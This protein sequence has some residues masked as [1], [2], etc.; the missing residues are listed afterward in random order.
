MHPNTGKEDRS[1]ESGLSNMDRESTSGIEAEM[2][3]ALP[4]GL[5]NR[6]GT[7]IFKQ[8]LTPFRS[9]RWEIHWGW[10]VTRA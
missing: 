8:K 7:N 9:E 6:V 1:S 4:R 3:I 10:S 5:D 2:E